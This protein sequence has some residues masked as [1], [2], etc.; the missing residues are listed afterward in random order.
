MAR[1][2]PSARK[3]KSKSAAKAVSPVMES[4]EGEDKKTLGRAARGVDIENRRTT[5]RKGMGDLKK[6]DELEAGRA[7]SRKVLAKELLKRG[8]GGKGIPRTT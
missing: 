1:P 2:K 6:Y 4:L 8:Y 7:A 3:A 5:A